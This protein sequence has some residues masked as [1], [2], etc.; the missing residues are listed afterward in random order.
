MRSSL[1]VLAVVMATLHLVRT[2]LARRRGVLLVPTARRSRA[3]TLGVSELRLPERA[4][5][6]GGPAEMGRRRGRKGV[7]V[8][9]DAT[10][11]RFAEW[12]YYGFRRNHDADADAAVA[13]P[14]IVAGAPAVGSVVSA[15]PDD[16]VSTLTEGRVYFRCGSV[17][18]Q[19]RHSGS[20]V[21]YVVV[22]AP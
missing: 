4:A 17:W 20:D 14:E 6:S 19:P 21:V 1:F 5:D 3:A 13:E 9:T 22:H 7:A 11:S 8:E 18:Y 2:A 15:L 10:S 16:C 12:R